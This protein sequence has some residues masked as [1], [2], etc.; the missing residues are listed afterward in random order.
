MARVKLTQSFVKGVQ[1]ASKGQIYYVDIGMPGFGLRVGAKSKSYY[2]QKKIGPDDVRVTVGNA[3]QISLGDAKKSAIKEFAKL[4]AGINPNDEKKRSVSIEKMFSDCIKAKNLSVSTE[5]LYS[6]C[7][8]IYFKDWRKRPA[9]WLTRAKVIKR[10]SELGERTKSRANLSMKILHAVFEWGKVK[11]KIKENPVRVLTEERLW[12]PE[13]RRTNHITPDNLPLL[14]KGIS[15]LPVHLERTYFI[16]ILY[17]GLRRSEGIGLQWNDINFMKNTITVRRTKNGD[18][19]TIPLPGIVRKML[20][21]EKKFFG[22][23]FDFEKSLESKKRK[24]V[25]NSLDFAI[26]DLRRT[27]ATIASNLGVPKTTIKRLLNH[28]SVGDITD[29]YIIQGDD[30]LFRASRKIEAYITKKAGA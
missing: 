23:V 9:S 21:R 18:D 2:V 13:N 5:R 11:Y 14:I 30:D 12:F 6:E 24:V 27:Y 20:E 25:K 1:F 16:M 4:T 10:H 15:S 26:H 19:H 8:N 17:T 7:I 28:R 3:L 29:S 22:K